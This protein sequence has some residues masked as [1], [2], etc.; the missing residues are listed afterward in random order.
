MDTLSG[1]WPMSCQVKPRD[2]GEKLDD[3][4]RSLLILR[5]WVLWRAHVGKWADS[6]RCR[7]EHF[8]DF[9]TSLERDVKSLNAP[10]GLLGD[11][12]ANQQFTSLVPVLAARLR[13]RGG[14]A[15]SSNVGAMQLCKRTA[16][17]FQLTGGV[18]ALVSTKPVPNEE[19]PIVRLCKGDE[20]DTIR[21]F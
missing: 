4:A 10:C 7:A 21:S 8:V 3:P 16:L 12:T 18:E 9:Q 5:G 19:P 2:Y 13:T 15:S 17:A 11:A 20:V 1:K 14:Q 6:R